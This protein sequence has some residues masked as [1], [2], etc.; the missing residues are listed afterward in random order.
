MTAA[1]DWTTVAAD[2]R[3]RAH[4]ATVIAGQVDFAGVAPE[5]FAKRARSIIA[6]GYRDIALALVDLAENAEEYA[7][8]AAAHE[9]AVA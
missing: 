8:S 5:W 9:G 7:V 6:E 4:A 2:C 3:R 1:A